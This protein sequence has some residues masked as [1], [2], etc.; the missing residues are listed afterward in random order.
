M[1]VV[2]LK[3]G[4][5]RPGARA[6]ATHSG[7][8][9]GSDRALDA[10]LA[11]AGAVRVHT[12]AELAATLLLSGHA[13][14][15][16]PGGLVTVHDSGGERSL[17]IDL[18]E[19]AG[20][21]LAVPG[22]ATRARLAARLGE[23]VTAENP[24]DAWDAA[25]GWP[26]AAR[27]GLVALLSDT[28]AALGALV[29]DR[30][31]DGDVWPEYHALLA[32]VREQTAKPVCLVANHNG[33]GASARVVAMCRDGLPVLDGVDTFL[34]AVRRL[35]DWRDAPVAA[36][37]LPT[38]PAQSLLST[39]RSRLAGGACLYEA[40]ALALLDAAG[41]DTVPRR[42]AETRDELHAAAAALG[43]PLAL[44]TLAP[45]AHR[46]DVGGVCLALRDGAALDAAFDDLHGRFREGVLVQR[47]VEG[48][49]VMLGAVDDPQFGVLVTL[50]AGGVDA[51]LAD[52]AV[53]LV[54]PFGPQAARRAFAGLR[55]SRLLAGHRGAPPVDMDALCGTAARFSVL[56]AALAGS[57]SAIDVNPL[58]ARA[59]G[60]TA[61][62]ALA[63]PADAAGQADD[64]C[65]GAACGAN[66]SSTEAR[67]C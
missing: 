18:A 8:L 54:A 23:A 33:T 34:A 6:V 31:P 3:V 29:C 5:T 55:L 42:R 53:T 57:F 39:W 20:V 47:M 14:E 64:P 49:E 37:P 11:E 19:R 50:A 44:K 13:R 15:L 28:G 58:L 51:E 62:D 32:S 4:A 66:D 35:L 21:P 2:V 16:A 52:D 36:E 59:D 48:V 65:A 7:A 38:P 46:S 9:A 24:L 61:V 10:V 45:V 27:E 12:F 56:A 30:S 26:G 25:P 41:I 17:L 1:P 40:E 63:L 22:E 67:A 43:H 60:C